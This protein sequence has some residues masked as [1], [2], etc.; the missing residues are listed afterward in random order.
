MDQKCTNDTRNV[1]MYN[2]DLN[3]NLEWLTRKTQDL[4]SKK[5]NLTFP[6]Y[7]VNK[8]EL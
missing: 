1:Q 2:K 5:W 4:K 3:D 6:T 7:A 8:I